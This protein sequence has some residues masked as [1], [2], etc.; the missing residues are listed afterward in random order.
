[1]DSALRAAQR[2]SMAY[3]DHDA[4]YHRAM[5]A[6]LF[7]DYGEPLLHPIELADTKCTQ[8]LQRPFAYSD[9][10]MCIGCMND[11]EQTV[12]DDYKDIVGYLPM[13]IYPYRSRGSHSIV[14]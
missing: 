12:Y 10:V 6:E 4:F 5:R 7:Y 13:G 2:H 3:G 8:C 11:F 14:K 9:E 1:M